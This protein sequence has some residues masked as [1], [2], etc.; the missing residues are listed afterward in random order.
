MTLEAVIPEEEEHLNNCNARKKDMNM[1]V[2]AHLGM[3]EQFIRTPLRWVL[4]WT[5]RGSSVPGDGLFR[6]CMC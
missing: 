2:N 5:P 6:L 3:E 1:H 4:L